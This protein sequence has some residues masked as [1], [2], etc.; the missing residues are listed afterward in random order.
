[1]TQESHNG[2]GIASMVCGMIAF[3]CFLML[4]NIPLAVAAIVLGIMQLVSRQKKVYAIIGMTTAVLSL[5]LMITGWV[6]I[7][8]GLAEAD[9]GSLEQFQQQIIQQYYDYEEM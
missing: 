1:M 8:V 6:F 7:A 4:I 2:L 9:S 5:L 3:V